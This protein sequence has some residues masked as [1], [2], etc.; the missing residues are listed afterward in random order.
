MDILTPE[1]RSWNMSRIRGKDT[2]PELVVRSVL[3]SM[4]Y[5]FRVSN[6]DFPGKPDILLPK[7]K[8]VIFVHG[9]FWHRHAGCKYAYFPK[10]NIE[11]W[12]NKFKANINRDQVVT[13]EIMEKGWQQFVIWECE[14]KD[15]DCVRRVLKDFFGDKKQHINK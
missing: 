14:T 5:R 15:K 11:F 13:R 1:K 10:S 7:H 9:C 2:K 4:G 12:L 8:I 3:H 6:K